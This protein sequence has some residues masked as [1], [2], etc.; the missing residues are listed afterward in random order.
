MCGTG[1]LRL[2]GAAFIAAVA[3]ERWAQAWQ[4][5]GG[6]RA[7]SISRVEG[8]HVRRPPRLA[9]DHAVPLDWN[10]LLTHRFTDPRSATNPPMLWAPP[11][12]ALT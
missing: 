1:S 3:P 2:L 11:R 7:K 6:V 9:A 12:P 10:P 8:A 4:V 5:R